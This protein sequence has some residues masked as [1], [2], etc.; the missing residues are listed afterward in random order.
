MNSTN[1]LSYDL[2][3][4]L[5]RTSLNLDAGDLLIMLWSLLGTLAGSVDGN[6]VQDMKP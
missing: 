4:L 2:A 6:A 1:R 5:D 3:G